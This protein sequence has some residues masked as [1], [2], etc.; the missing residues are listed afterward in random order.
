MI[1]GENAYNC[2]GTNT[3]TEVC[4]TTENLNFS[5]SRIRKAKTSSKA[6]CTNTIYDDHSSVWDPPPFT[7][8]LPITNPLKTK[9]P[10]KHHAAPT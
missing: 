4:Q 9:C 5:A 6:K 2:F 1:L 10:F 7:G 3:I 8:C